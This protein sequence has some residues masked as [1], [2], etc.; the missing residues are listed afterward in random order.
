[1]QRNFPSADS[2][3]IPEST[4]KFST[5]FANGPAGKAVDVG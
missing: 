4:G 1:M 5:P 2:N 3:G